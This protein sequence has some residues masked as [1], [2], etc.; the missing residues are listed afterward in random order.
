MEESSLEQQGIITSLKH[1]CQ[2]LREQHLAAHVEFNKEKQSH[3][4]QI[5][6]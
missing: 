5:Q 1:T 6:D 2:D 3:I 4:A